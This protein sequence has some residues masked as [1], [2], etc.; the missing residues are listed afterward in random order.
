MRYTRLTVTSDAPST[1]GAVNAYLIHGALPTLIDAPSGREDFVEQ[2]TSA[3]AAAGDGPLAML[4]ATHAHAD[5]ISGAAAVAARWPSA[6]RLKRPWPV[7]DEVSGTVWEP[8]VGEP[9]LPAG[10]ARLWVIDT[11]GHAPD[12]A[13]LLD[14]ASATLFAGDLVINGGTVGIPASDEGDLAEYLRSLRK[15]LELQPRRM[16]PSHGTDVE[17]PASLLRGYISHRLLRERQILEL[18]AGGVSGPDRIVERLYASLD[19][20]LEPSARENV[21]AHLAKLEAEGLAVQ[22][23]A[24]W[25]LGGSRGVTGRSANGDTS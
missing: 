15:V 14:V 7:R 17:Q 5:H 12:H 25:T 2:V 3:L 22:V 20:A 16:L 11:P 1:G 10:D 21:L 13:C 19:P 9:M 4:I 23:G 24:E 6:R 18:L 8:L